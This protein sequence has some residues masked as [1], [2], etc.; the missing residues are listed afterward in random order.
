[1][2]PYIM[3]TL[4]LILYII[5]GFSIGYDHAYRII[6]LR[7][8]NK[9]EFLILLTTFPIS[10]PTFILALVFLATFKRKQKIER[11]YR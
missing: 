9:T 2:T 8:L 11:M 7:K 1:M 5:F 4:S 3:L 6:N 10:F